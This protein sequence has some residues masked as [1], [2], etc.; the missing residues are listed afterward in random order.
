M[1]T[2]LKKNDLQKSIKNYKNLSENELFILLK[3]LDDS[4]Y[5][6]SSIISDIEYDIMREYA[7]NKYPN[8]TYF[9]CI[10][11]EIS[12]NE[13]SNNETEEENDKETENNFNIE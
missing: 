6:D 3:Q 5:N 7:E 4:Y 1:N 8:N 13:T 12:N 11:Y 9:Q 2:I 10:G